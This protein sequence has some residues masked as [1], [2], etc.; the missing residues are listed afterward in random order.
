M[1]EETVFERAVQ[2]PADERPALL[3]RECAGQA[4]RTNYPKETS[5]PP[6]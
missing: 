1:T 2:L 5:K 3:D 4:E 6:R